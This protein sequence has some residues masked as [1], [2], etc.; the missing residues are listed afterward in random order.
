MLEKDP[1]GVA[2]SAH[3]MNAAAL[4]WAAE[5]DNASI[6]S[7]PAA[8]WILEV[9]CGDTTHYLLMALGILIISDLQVCLVPQFPHLLRVKR[10]CAECFRFGVRKV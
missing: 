2:S 1:Q 8:R 9:L 7:Q 6:L 3:G 4:G 5:H 10:S